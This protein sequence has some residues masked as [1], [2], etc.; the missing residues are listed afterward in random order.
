MLKQLFVTLAAVTAAA[1]LAA[2][3]TAIGTSRNGYPLIIPQPKELVPASGSFALP[4]ELTVSAPQDFD[5]SP[6]AKTYAATVKGG[7]VAAGAKAV[8]RFEL[9]KSGVPESVE[10]YTLTVGTDGIAVK[11]RDER[12]LFYGMQT[13][14]WMLRNREGDALK[15]CKINDWPD[16]EMRGL[17]F[18]LP[19][20][21]PS[22]VD[23]LCEVIDV[24]ANLKYNMILIEF[25][26]NLPMKNSPY[27]KRKET[28]SYSDVD[29]ILAAA[30]RNRI[31]LV[32]KLQ[33]ASHTLWMASHRDWAKLSEGEVPKPWR[34]LYCLSNPAVQP[35]VEE[36][37]SATCDL[38]EPRYF[39][40]GLDEIT[41]C[42][43]PI[44]PKCKKAN[45]TELL[46]N[47][48]RPIKKLLNDRGITPIIYH[49]EFFRLVSGPT[50]TKN[51]SMADFPEKLG[52]DVVINS[53]EY[54]NE[55]TPTMGR[56]IRA[57]GF[58][59]LLY[60]SYSI[61]LG[62]SWKLPK[63]ARELNAKGNILAHW[64]AAP[65][66]L[67]APERS[68]FNSYPSIVA[69]A[70]YS[71]NTGDIDFNRIPIDS[72]QVLRRIVDGNAAITFRGEA[73]P[74]P[75]TGIFNRE[76]GA[77]P[78]FPR[79]DGKLAA[80]VKRIAAADPAK[81]D[82]AVRDDKIVAAVLSGTQN[83]GYPAKALT[84]PVG[85]RASGAAF[86]MAS[87]IFNTF[88]AT[89][90]KVIKVGELKIVYDQGK[91][92]AVP[93]VLRQN[94]N[95]WNT[96]VGGNLCRAVLRGNDAAGA[97]FSLYSVEWKNPRPRSVI[98]N[99]VFSSDRKSGIATALFALSLADAETAPEGAP[100]AAPKL[101]A[102][103]KPKPAKLRPLFDLSGG[104][105]AGTKKS[106]MATKRFRAQV[107]D[108]PQQGKM[109]EIKVEGTTDQPARC[110]VDL[111][112]KGLKEF[113]YLVFKLK[114]NDSSAIMRPDVYWMVQKPD[115]EFRALAALKFAPALESGVWQTVCLPRS[116]FN[117]KE[118][119]G[120]ELPEAKL[121][122]LSFF[123]RS[124]IKPLMIRIGGF[125]FT[126]EPVGGRINVKTPAL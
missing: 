80:E 59:E 93:L 53:W 32:P 95:D 101:S 87:S 65:A 85:T 54:N 79:L 89:V 49:D 92:V 114:V 117:E 118:H 100:A 35:V 50:P 119:G 107:V 69:Q 55:P 74:V 15:A 22:K 126:D 90:T 28:F 48:V 81:F 19:R 110:C 47:H 29:K 113:K 2:D 5:L 97:L 94:L 121:M 52:R 57:R 84:I 38:V 23:R 39:H 71:W 99:I 11:A 104:F 120:V 88:A 61:N 13:L 63:I 4:A 9:A 67:D 109:I 8:C 66:T 44:C 58:E 83:D 40:I 36:L 41:L 91:P 7:K 21:S 14:T 116:R 33:V 86:L 73:A 45:L 62:N 27:T 37:I 70:N 124:P 77:D 111:P 123:L 46:L 98:K 51:S 3:V 108:D 122:R 25:A 6:L 106:G 16:L 34:S 102:A 31:E 30:K 60:M 18:E 76:I 43:Y 26:D 75:L 68:N 17:F 72:A 12:G 78:Q 105:P 42:G 96:F 82:V 10:G 125:G 64:Y 20:I 115:G 56:N 112:V 103:A 24:L 1:Q